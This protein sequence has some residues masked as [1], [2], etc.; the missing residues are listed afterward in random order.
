MG[1]ARQTRRSAVWSVLFAGTLLSLLA[2]TGAASTSQEL[3]PLVVEVE[4]QFGD[5]CAPRVHGVC[6][7]NYSRNGSFG[8]STLDLYHRVAYVGVAVDVTYLGIPLPGD[9]ETWRR[10]ATVNGSS[11]SAL[12]L[13]HI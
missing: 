4:D 5:E 10:E 11:L 9:E 2:P 8:D 6:V 12:S 1:G 13:I 3:G 7:A